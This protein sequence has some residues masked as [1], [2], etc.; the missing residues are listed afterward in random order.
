[1][2]KTLVEEKDWCRWFVSIQFRKAGV[3]A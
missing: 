2:Y 1:L 3:Y